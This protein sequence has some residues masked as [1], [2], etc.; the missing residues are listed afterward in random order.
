MPLVD[1]PFARGKDGYKLIQYMACAKPVIASPI[2]VN[3]DIVSSDVGFLPVDEDGWI[4]AFSTL[5]DDFA[6]REA[7]GRAARRKVEQGYCLQ[8][9]GPRLAAWLANLAHSH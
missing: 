4:N 8:V 7:M 6:K 1:Y 5:R 9:T 2:G 3:I